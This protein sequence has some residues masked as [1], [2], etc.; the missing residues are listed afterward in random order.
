MLSEALLEDSLPP[1]SGLCDES[2]GITSFNFDWN[3]SHKGW[4]SQYDA[5]LSYISAYASTH[6]ANLS[7]V[8]SWETT[9]NASRTHT[10]RVLT[11]SRWQARYNASLSYASTFASTHDPL[12]SY[13]TAW[14]AVVNS[15]KIHVVELMTSFTTWK[16]QIEHELRNVSVLTNVTNHTT[17]ITIEANVT[18]ERN[19]TV[20]T[21]VSVHDLRLANVSLRCAVENCSCSSTGVSTTIWGRDC[22]CGCAEISRANCR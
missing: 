12:L 18:V 16:M 3:S 4:R 8:T 6:N 20:E 9:V 17:N 2:G 7:Y 14:Q 21:N 19:M 1:S 10:I 15:S 11:N 13:I 22:G 5:G